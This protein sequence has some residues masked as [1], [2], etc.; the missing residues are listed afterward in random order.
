MSFLI[1]PHEG[2]LALV[3]EQPGQYDVVYITSP[4]FPFPVEGSETILELARSAL[5]VQFDDVEGAMDGLAA[6]Q[7][8]HVASVLD[9]AA[10]KSNF[11]ISCRAGISRSSATAVVIRASR[12]PIG[13]ALEVLVP[14]LHYPNQLVVQHGEA[15]L[16]KPGLADAVREWKH[17]RALAG[18]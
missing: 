12:M 18:E 10:G 17:V 15:I 3:R 13:E 14:R 8:H 16:G 4:L 6:P 9:W 7:R 1:R 2:A 11:L 5:M